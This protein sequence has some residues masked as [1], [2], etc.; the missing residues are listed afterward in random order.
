MEAVIVTVV[1]CEGVAG[2]SQ[3]RKKK[4][5]KIR[6][7]PVSVQSFILFIFIRRNRQQSNKKTTNSITSKLT[8]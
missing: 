7:S 1:G 5:R 3:S 6:S 8:S 4:D 2:Y